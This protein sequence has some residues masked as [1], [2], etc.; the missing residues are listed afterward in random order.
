[1]NKLINT[2]ITNEILFAKEVGAIP[3]RCVENPE[4]KK[5]ITNP[6]PIAINNP[7]SEAEG[8]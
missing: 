8:Q 1:M 7:V 5:V 2:G 4:S 6:I 3:F